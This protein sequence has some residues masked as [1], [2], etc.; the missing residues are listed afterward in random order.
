MCVDLRFN[1]PETLGEGDGETLARL[2]R[3]LA[4]SSGDSES[5]GLKGWRRRLLRCIVKS[6]HELK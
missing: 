3:R 6:G 5:V 1:W 4:D 2:R